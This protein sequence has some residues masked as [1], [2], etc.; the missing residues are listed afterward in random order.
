MFIEHIADLRRDVKG[1]IAQ[2][3]ENRNK[4]HYSKFYCFFFTNLC[5]FFLSKYRIWPIKIIK[6]LAFNEV[7]FFSKKTIEIT[8]RTNPAWVNAN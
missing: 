1:G 6:K 8:I 7:V 2:L 4:A 5:D 3:L